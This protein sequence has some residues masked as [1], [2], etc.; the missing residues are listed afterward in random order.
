MY[1]T[2]PHIDPNHIV[3]YTDALLENA[4]AFQ[5]AAG[6]PHSSAT[7]PA[8]LDRLDETLKLLSAAWCEIAADAAPAIVE[9][10]GRTG[11][12]ETLPVVES[13]LSHE[14]EVHLMATLHDVSAAFA[15]CAHTCREGRSTVAPLIAAT[16][17]RG[18]TVA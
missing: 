17:E 3:Q 10:W 14:Q 16:Q 13:E 9:R 4:R 8:V 1:A 7:A 11:D 2:T 18:T 6:R 15:R 5:A 12:D